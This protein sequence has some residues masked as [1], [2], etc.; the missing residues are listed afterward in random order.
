MPDFDLYTNYKKDAGIASV[1]IGEQKPVLDVEFN[2]MQ[3]IARERTRKFIREFFGEGIIGKGTMTYVD[4]TFTIANETAVVDGELLTVS[5]L[6]ITL[7]EGNSVYLDVWD[8]QVTVTSTLK[9]EGNEQE[10]NNITNYLQDARVGAETSQRMVVAFNLSTTN[11]TEG[12][13]YLKLGT[14]TSGVFVSSVLFVNNPIQ[15]SSIAPS[16]PVQ[17]KLWVDIS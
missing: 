2:E 17:G 14:I 6:S 12:H 11:A 1:R 10:S 5:S 4:T 7:A 9:K 8:K 15:V 3:E 16:T 13:R